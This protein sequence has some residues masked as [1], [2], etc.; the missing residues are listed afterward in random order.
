MN[1]STEKNANLSARKLSGLI[2]MLLAVLLFWHVLTD[3]LAPS[4]SRGAVKAYVTQL[5]PL[6]AGQVTQ[7]LVAD[8]D[9][10]Q[11]GQPL[12]TIDNRNYQLAVRQAGNQ[13]ASAIKST[14]ASA[15]SILSSQASVNEA[16]INL[17]NTRASSNRAL[18]LAKRNLLSS[19]EADN[20]RAR[21]KSAQATYEKAKAALESSLLALGASDETNLEVQAARI[22]LEQAQ[23]NL[24]YTTAKAPTQGVIT[25]LS[26]AIGQ[27]VAPGNPAL[28]F[29]DSR[30]AWI[31]IDLRENQLGNIDIG[32][33]AAIS[34]DAV[35]GKVYHGV[36]KAI[37][38]GIDPGRAS[39]NGLQQNQ[40]ANQWFEPARKIPLHIELD[41]GLDNWPQQAKA[42]GKVS[43]LI[44]ASGESNPVAWLS[45]VL[46]W[47]KSMFSYLY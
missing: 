22:A 30:G 24:E 23:L 15:A 32:D 40:A 28:T 18:A 9:I 11:P 41:G 42:G 8:G 1:A 19:A 5:S 17:E 7:V 46:F 44:Y 2:L 38:W 21:L 33:S 4:S 27:Y 29:I 47:F 35:P 12:F 25:N 31:S 45:A 43:A 37:A 14:R 6:V 20:A 26:L 10:V 16:R 39:A 13:L 3:R 36:V 34:F